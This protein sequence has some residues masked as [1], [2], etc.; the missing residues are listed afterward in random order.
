MIPE[1]IIGDIICQEFEKNVDRWQVKNL[2][3]KKPMK[4]MEIKFSLSPD[5]PNEDGY[6]HLT[7][8][9]FGPQNYVMVLL[10]EDW[11]ICTKGKKQYAKGDTGWIAA[12]YHDSCWR[13][14]G[15]RWIL[16]MYNE[17]ISTLDWLWVK[18]GAWYDVVEISQEELEKMYKLFKERDEGNFS[19][20]R[21]GSTWK[22]KLPVITQIVHLRNSSRSE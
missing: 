21:N 6:R 12:S 14:D 22:G 7:I 19:N 16:Q 20:H 3:N 11:D 5:Y 15:I 8:R 2:A 10:K 13:E 1:W 4:A 18:G 17:V 9:I